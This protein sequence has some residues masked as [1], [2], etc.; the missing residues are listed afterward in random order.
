MISPF[1]P[2][3]DFEPQYVAEEPN[4][5]ESLFKLVKAFGIY[6]NKN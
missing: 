2:N 3:E 4:V 6:S 5:G 1:F